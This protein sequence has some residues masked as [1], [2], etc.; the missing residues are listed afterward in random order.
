MSQRKHL[1]NSEAWK[2][3]GRLQGGETQAEV[4][5]ATGVS[6]SVISRIWN[7]F[8]ETGSAGQSQRHTTAPNEERYLTLTAR[9]HRNMNATLLQ[10]HLHL[11][12]G[13][14]ISTETGSTL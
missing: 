9:R 3:V 8:L 4:A 11:A 1:T 5:E 7:H 2:I 14:T 13:T 10:Q 6:R 12:S